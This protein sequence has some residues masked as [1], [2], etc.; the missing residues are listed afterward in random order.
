MTNPF[1]Q[2]PQKYRYIVYI[3]A[4]VVVIAIGAWQ[5]AEGNVLN[6]IASFAS[7]LIP[8]MSASN[9]GPAIEVTKKEV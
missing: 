5:T 6:A 2:I 9:S 1:Q 3:V 7:A 4:T 8:L